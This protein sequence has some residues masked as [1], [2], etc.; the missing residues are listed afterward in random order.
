MGVEISHTTS[1]TNQF[2]IISNL[3]WV[4]VPDV[5]HVSTILDI[6]NFVKN[7]N[8]YELIDH[9]YIV[10]VKHYKNI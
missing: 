4:F 3:S 9:V 1:P 5:S 6:W 10:T 8:F 7:F 2:Q